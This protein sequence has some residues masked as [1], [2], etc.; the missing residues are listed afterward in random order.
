MARKGKGG[1]MRVKNKA[2]ERSLGAAY[3]GAHT[4]QRPGGD[5]VG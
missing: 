4:A 1:L 3:E 2:E 5:H